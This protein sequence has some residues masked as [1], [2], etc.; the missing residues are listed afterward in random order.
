MVGITGNTLELAP[1]T[2]LYPEIW[3]KINTILIR[4]VGIFLIIW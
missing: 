4:V 3:G 2:G 1:P